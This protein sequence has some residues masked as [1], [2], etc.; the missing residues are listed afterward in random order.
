MPGSATDSGRR[1]GGV[2]PRWHFGIRSQG[3][4][5]EVMDEV[6]RALANIGM[7]WKTL[8]P[9][10]VRARYL[11][12]DGQAVKVDLQLYSID[13]HLYLLDFCQANEP[14]RAPCRPTCAPRADELASPDSEPF[15]GRSPFP[16]FDACSRLITELALAS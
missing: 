16:F 8:D 13:Q 9:F 12:P 7:D 1:R 11:G 2:R 3:R 4:P 10:R 6:Y 15:V 5:L 14:T